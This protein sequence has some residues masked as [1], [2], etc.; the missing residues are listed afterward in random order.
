MV[1]KIQL[2]ENTDCALAGGIDMTGELER[3]GV[4]NVHVRRRNGKNNAVRLCNVLGDQVTRLLSI[5]E[6][7]S[8]IGTLV[9]PGKSTRV[10]L[11]T[12]EE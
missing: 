5:S 7:W 10:K 3:F 4:D 11:S 12:C 9:K 2:R 8:P 6:G 1:H